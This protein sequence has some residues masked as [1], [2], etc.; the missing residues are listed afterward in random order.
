VKTIAFLP[1]MF[2]A[3][4]FFAGCFNNTS[5]NKYPEVR[6]AATYGL[7]VAPAYV[8]A[9]L[10]LLE[11]YYPNVKVTFKRYG[12]SVALRNA[13][14]EGSVDIMFS[15]IITPITLKDTGLNFKIVS[16]VGFAPYELMVG[17][18]YGI[19]TL[20]DFTSQNRIVLPGYGS[21]PHLSI[22]MALDNKSAGMDN[23]TSILQTM[24]DPI[25]YES[26]LLGDVTAHF[27]T[28]PYT[29]REQ[30]KGF[31][32]I[33][34][35]QA[36][37]G[38]ISLVASISED[39]RY[40]H[41][42]IYAAFYAALAEAVELINTRDEAALEIISKTEDMSKKE[43]LE[44]LEHDGVVFT[45]K[46]YDPM[47]IVQ[48]LHK[49]GFIAELPVNVQDFMW[50]SAS[51]MLGKEWDVVFVPKKEKEVVDTDDVFDGEIPEE[52][53]EEE[54]ET[55]PEEIAGS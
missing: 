22:Y 50:E 49:F 24:A 1:I 20:N 46:I 15:S 35:S 6:I 31:H 11:K 25:G 16:G 51:S 2:L 54:V 39:F 36:I 23:I 45:T 33:L 48:L 38:D 12:S 26:L 28:F 14:V 37:L 52:N 55:V 7:G 34:S 5:K 17:D 9:D 42:E 13:V 18:S 3:F 8:I 53:F 27:T 41:P 44:A 21:I 32:S 10:K 40:K 4:V 43:L 30:A 29:T 19:Q 47:Q